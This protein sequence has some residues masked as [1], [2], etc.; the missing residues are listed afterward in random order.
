M[1]IFVASLALLAGMTVSQVAQAE[2]CDRHSA[3]FEIS[4]TSLRCA[5]YSSCS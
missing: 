3:C 4:K 1:K 2:Y 5:G